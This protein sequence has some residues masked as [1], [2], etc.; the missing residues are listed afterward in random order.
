MA[1][2]W[3]VQS[4]I[5]S[6]LS[7]KTDSERVPWQS[8]CSIYSVSC[9]GCYCCY[10]EPP[11][12]NLFIS[13]WYSRTTLNWSQPSP[14]ISAS[15]QIPAGLHNIHDSRHRIIL[16]GT[17]N[18]KNLVPTTNIIC[19]L[20]PEMFRLL[21]YVCLCFVS[22]FCRLS[23]LILYVWYFSSVCIYSYDVHGAYYFSKY[24]WCVCVEYP[25]LLL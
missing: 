25:E 13:L 6:G 10:L 22:F 18:I 5:S 14:T 17:I 7:F 12:Q 3:A 21:G 24:M 11:E 1:D 4:A 23:F 9:S 19:C 8:E 2:F 20:L 16:S 15:K